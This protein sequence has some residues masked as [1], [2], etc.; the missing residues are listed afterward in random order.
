MNITGLAELKPIL[1]RIAS[2]L[3]RIAPPAE[4]SVPDLKPEDA[5]LY[6]DEEKLERAQVIEELG[7]E[8]KLL[9]QWLRDH[10]DE[11]GAEVQSST[12]H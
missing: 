6:V 10:P 1:E 12:P 2:A 4:E 3:E 8:A 9:D 7:E 5:V 11:T